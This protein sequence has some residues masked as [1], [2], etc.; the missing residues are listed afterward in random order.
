MR[1]AKQAQD[2]KQWIK[3]NKKTPQPVMVGIIYFVLLISAIAFGVFVSHL[4]KP[5]TKLTSVTVQQGDTLWSIAEEN[6]PNQDPREVVQEIESR[7]RLGEY[8]CPGDKLI[9]PQGIRPAQEAQR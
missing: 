2:L 7:N 3:V 9:V 4:D 1:E 8:L 5:E 6:C